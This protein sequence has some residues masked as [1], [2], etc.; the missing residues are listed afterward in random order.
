MARKNFTVAYVSGTRADFGLMTPVLR[1]IKKTPGLK[2]RLYATGMHLMKQFG[3][4]VNGVR[5]QFPDAIRLPSTIQSDTPAGLAAFFADLSRLLTIEFQKRRPDYVV[6]LGDRAEM[7]AVASVCLYLGIPTG[8]IH[9]GEKSGTAD[10]IARQAITKLSDQHFAATKLSASRIRQMGEEAWRIHTVGAPGLDIIRQYQLSSGRQLRRKLG[11]PIREPILLVSLHPISDQWQRA[12]QQMREVLTAVKSWPS[13]V[14][15]L[16]PNADA[17]G[18]KMI[19]EIEKYRRRLRFHIFPNLDYATFLAL[20]RETSVW[21]GNSSAGMIESSTWPTPV[22]N[23]GT[24]QAGRERGRNVIDAAYKHRDIERAIH[25]AL[26]D[27]AWRR[28]MQRS[29]NPWGD[30]RT[31]KRIATIIKRHPPI[32]RLLAKRLTYV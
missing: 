18:K 30:G 3:S 22:V 13:T 16:Y 32:E 17:G 15:V 25:R 7:L 31:G 23:V 11:L 12:P 20:Q 19:A 6:V 26:N 1:A 5:R 8:H 24:R 14:V 9:G 29:K 2:L 27:R 21:V 4:T 28:I 10:D